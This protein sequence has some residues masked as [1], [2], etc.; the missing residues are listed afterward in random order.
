M[1]TKKAR[2]AKRGHLG[3]MRGCPFSQKG[4]QRLEGSKV[5]DPSRH[6]G[7]ASRRRT[8]T[9]ARAPRWAHAHAELREERG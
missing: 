7:R 4:E 9:P 5:V 1:E 6:L 3:L 2:Q 8:G